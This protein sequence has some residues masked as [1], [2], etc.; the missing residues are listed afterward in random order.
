MLRSGLL[1]SRT[2][3][4]KPSRRTFSS[5]AFGDRTNFISNGAARRVGAIAITGALGTTAYLSLRK[6]VRADAASG[7]ESSSSGSHQTPL[8]VLLRSYL[9][10][11]M[12]AIPTLVDHSPAILAT[13]SSIPGLKQVAESFVRATFF[14]QVS[15][16]L[17]GIYSMSRCLSYL[18]VV[19]W[20]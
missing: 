19:C 14:A 13:L 3:R 2:F 5:S 10:F 1:L 8:S 11:S 16:I 20:R 15:S 7:G 9:V 4:L 6:P 17:Y 12:C 18:P